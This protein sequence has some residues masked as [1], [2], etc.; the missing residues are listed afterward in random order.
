MSKSE[1]FER[2]AAAVADL[3]EQ[4]PPGRVTTYG[5]IGQALGIGPRYVARIMATAPEIPGTP[6]HRVVGADGRI[7]AGPHRAEQRRRLQ[8]EGVT[9]NGDGIVAFKTRL[10]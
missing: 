9:M 6:W 7:K 2:S 4:I 5:A 1:V 3:V 10:R 8:A